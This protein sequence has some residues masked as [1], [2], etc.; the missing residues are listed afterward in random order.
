MPS[1]ITLAIQA[2]GTG[3]G[4]AP[5]ITITPALGDMISGATATCTVSGRIINTIIVTNNGMDYNTLPTVLLSGDGGS[6][7]NIT[8]TFLKTYSYSWFVPDVV[9]NDLAQL[10]A[11]NIIATGFTA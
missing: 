2:G 10:S 1:S 9:I 8:P 5:T 6:Y 3:Y 7:G 4:T 11:V